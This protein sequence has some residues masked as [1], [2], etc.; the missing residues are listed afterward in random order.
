M[1]V[2]II[3]T[4]VLVWIQLEDGFTIP[5]LNNVS[6]VAAKDEVT[7][8]PL[9]QIVSVVVVS[10]KHIHVCENNFTYG[11]LCTAKRMLSKPL[12]VSVKVLKMM[13]LTL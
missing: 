5:I 13:I 12:K 8:S 2:H 4:L 10:Q 9:W 1:S 3:Q 11:K 6:L 7:Y